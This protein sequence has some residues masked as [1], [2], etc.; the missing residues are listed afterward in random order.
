MQNDQVPAHLTKFPTNSS[1]DCNSVYQQW[2]NVLVKPNCE[3]YGTLMSPKHHTY[4][5]S[6][7]RV[8]HNSY[9]T[10]QNYFERHP[11]TTFR[12]SFSKCVYKKS[13]K[14]RAPS[15]QN[16]AEQSTNAETPAFQT[17]IRQMYNSRIG[18]IGLQSEVSSKIAHI[19][20]HGLHMKVAYYQRHPLPNVPYTYFGDM[21]N[22]VANSDIV[23]LADDT[24]NEIPSK[25]VRAARNNQLTFRHAI[26]PRIWLDQKQFAHF[27]PQALLVCVTRIQCIDFPALFLALRYGQLGGAG[28]TMPTVWFTQ[29]S[30]MD[31]LRLLPNTFILPPATS[32]VCAP[33]EVRQLLATKVVRLLTNV[34]LEPMKSRNQRHDEQHNVMK[35]TEPIETIRAPMSHGISTKQN[36]SNKKRSFIGMVDRGQK[37]CVQAAFG[38]IRRYWKEK[39]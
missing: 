16:N 11:R 26:R 36:C 18:L 39:Q 10:V 30:D 19:A 34:L 7:H 15:N 35:E 5:T 3:V 32:S 13:H 14:S 38:L 37:M 21:K 9:Q 33:T 6:N 31:C 27:R 8:M 12:K 1:Q 2:L 23:I 20:Y 4:S 22:L 17:S 24:M 25:I 29:L 28:V